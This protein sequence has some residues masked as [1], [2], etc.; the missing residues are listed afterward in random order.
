MDQHSL[1]RSRLV[2]GSS[3]SGSSLSSKAQHLQRPG[4]SSRAQQ[5]RP[6][7]GR[8]APA[9]EAVPLAQLAGAPTCIELDH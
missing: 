1:C 4:L 2:P 7:A 9:G 6:W 5:A 3:S 8:K